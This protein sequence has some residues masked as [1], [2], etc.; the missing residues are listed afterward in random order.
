MNFFEDDGV[1]HSH[2]QFNQSNSQQYRPS[3]NYQR[4]GGYQKDFKKPWQNN[5]PGFKK[6]F[7]KP[8]P[9]SP[10]EIRVYK[11][12][13]VTGNKECPP[14]I[15][16]RVKNIVSKLDK[17]N[18]VLRTG[19][20]EGAEE[21]AETSVTN[22][23]NIELHLPWKEFAGKTSKFM[24]SNEL[25]KGIAKIF[26]PSFDTLPLP[27]QGF[28][29]KNVR[30]VYGKDGKSPAMFVVVYSEDGAESP[31]EKTPKTGNILHVL[32]LAAATH[33]PIFNLGKP[34]AEERLYQFLKLESN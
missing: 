4:D 33:I 13:A 28:L 32:S 26:Q 11:A 22:Q 17:A 14:H 25:V 24:Y 23:L 29:S 31:S 19:G 18:F 10:E 34:D 5:K 15:L 3:N 6:P 9:L 7:T 1:D 8:E 21:T 12:Y 27:V 2:G 16:G 20:L 30:L